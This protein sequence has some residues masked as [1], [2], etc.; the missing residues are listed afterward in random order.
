MPEN[1]A[2]V[3]RGYEAFSRGDLTK[4]TELCGDDVSWHTPG[5][6]PLAGDAVGRQAVFARL[7]R[8]L[9]ETGGTFRADLKRLLTDE[10]G[11]VIGIHHNVAE[12]DGKRL[13]RLRARERPDRRRARALPRPPG[14]GRV[15]VVAPT[16]ASPASPQPPAIRR[17]RLDSPRPRHGSD[18]SSSPKG[19]RLRRSPTRQ[20]S[21]A[22]RRPV[23]WKPGNARGQRAA[24]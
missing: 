14:L 24:R 20:A 13:H 3:R 1:A 11:R 10:D 12:R 23:T 19:C 21:K 15:L 17:G 4:L 22:Q 9:A 8:Y 5:R 18:R 2:I 6:S 7:G 16:S